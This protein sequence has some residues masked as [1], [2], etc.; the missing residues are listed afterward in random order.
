MERRATGSSRRAPPLAGTE[1]LDMPGDIAST[2]VDGCDRFL[3]RKIDESVAARVGPLRRDCASRLAS[4]IGAG[5]ARCCLRTT[6]SSSARRDFP[7]LTTG[8][9]AGFCVFAVRWPAFGD[10]HGEGLLL[11]P[12]TSTMWP[13]WWPFPTPITRPRCLPAWSPACRPESQF[14]RRLAE[15]GCRVL[16]PVLV[17]P[18]KTQVSQ[19]SP[20]ASSSTARHIELGRHLIGYEVQ[21]VLA[22]PPRSIGNAT[23]MIA[24]GLRRVAL[25]VMAG[26]R[27]A[28]SPS[29]PRRWIPRID[30]ACVSGYFDSRQNVWQEPLD[31]NVFGLLGAIRR[32]GVRLPWWRRGRLSSRRPAGRN[33]SFRPAPAAARAAWS[34]RR[35]TTCAAELAGS[36]AGRQ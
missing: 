8:A 28:C 17:E 16:V 9:G 12:G 23:R 24:L 33:T 22:G 5:D 34:R 14:A 2:L 7:R 32:R 13:T 36:E 30:A 3:L 19:H 1:R 20:T 31:R 10:V 6:W 18:C 26:A 35:W 21:K 11:L 25:R 29:M 4:L 27:A 15:S